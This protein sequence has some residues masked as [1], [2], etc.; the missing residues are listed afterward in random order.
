MNEIA[1]ALNTTL[2]NHVS[3]KL[4]SSLGKRMYFPQGIVAQTEQSKQATIKATAGI[5]LDNMTP[6]MLDS[7]RKKLSSMESKD[8][9]AYA[10]A[11]GIPELRKSWQHRQLRLNPSLNASHISTPIVSSGL[12][13]GIHIGAS[14]F[15]DKNDTVITQEYIWDNYEHILETHIEANI[16]RCAIFNEQGHFQA[17]IFKKTL[18]HIAQKQN[19]I[20]LMLN[21]PNNPTGQC[22]LQKDMNSL[23]N[24][25]VDI[26][27]TGIPIAVLCDDAY[28]SMF[29][30][31]ETM[32]TSLFSQLASLHENVLAIKIDGATKELLVWGLR[33]GFITFGNPNLSDS[34]T[35]ALE[36]KVIGLIRATITSSSRLSQSLVL[37]I[38]QNNN[39]TKE[40]TTVFELLKTKYTIVKSE[41]KKLSIEYPSTPITPLHFN[42]GYFMSFNC[43][44]ISAK[45]L[46]MVLLEKEKIALIQIDNLL[47]FTFASV[48]KE[49]IPHVLKKIYE[50]AQILAT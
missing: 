25:I 22:L 47:R 4:F 13:H 12:T 42:G 27:K 37:D 49:D 7:I 11:S 20:I 44:T 8:I 9:V 28:F 2:K 1:L 16:Q 10:P 36:Q 41:L 31:D 30:D 48:E 23:C 33:V 38:L 46:R 35:Y 40:L 50:Q 14:L 5:A 19:K 29:Y 24:I 26:T 21:F 43:N 45:E 18:E 15:I 3:S 6:L 32:K 17:D 34:I 39:T